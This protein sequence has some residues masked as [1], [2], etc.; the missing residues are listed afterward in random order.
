MVVG[1]RWACLSISESADLQ[2]FSCINTS[3]VY[4]IGSEKEKLSNEQHWISPLDENGL[5]MMEGRG[6]W[7]GCFE[8][9]EGSNSKNSWQQRY[10]EDVLCIS[11]CTTH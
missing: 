11:E 1:A 7:P 6:E 9:M 4:R 5:L 10:A 2:G 3:R 8:E